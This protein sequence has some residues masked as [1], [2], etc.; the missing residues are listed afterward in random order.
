MLPLLSF[1]A[2]AAQ[3]GDG[4]HPVLAA[5]LKRL[6]AESGEHA[7]AELGRDEKRAAGPR[8]RSRC[9]DAQQ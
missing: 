1:H 3:Q 5:G 6:A 2:I 4:L 9:A 8:G 7:A